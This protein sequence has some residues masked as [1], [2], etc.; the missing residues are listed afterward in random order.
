MPPS[1]R[2]LVAHCATR[3]ESLSTGSVARVDVFNLPA[4]YRGRASWHIRQL[5]TA[6]TLTYMLAIQFLGFCEF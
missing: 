6:Y 3:R 2:W 5:L 1:D 4:I